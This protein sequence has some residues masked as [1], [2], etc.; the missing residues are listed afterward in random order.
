MGYANDALKIIF[1]YAAACEGGMLKGRS[2]D[3]RPESY[4]AQ[5]LKEMANPSAMPDISITLKYGMGMYDTLELR[6]NTSQLRDDQITKER[7][8][9]RLRESGYSN[10]VEKLDEQGSFEAQLHADFDLLRSLYGEPNRLYATWKIVRGGPSLRWAE[11][12]ELGYKPE[13]RKAPAVNPPNVAKLCDVADPELLVKQPAVDYYQLRGWGYS[14]IGTFITD[15]SATEAAYPGS[16]RLA[17]KAMRDTVDA[18]TLVSKDA[19]VDFDKE[20]VEHKW[21]REDFT[22][23]AET[24]GQTEAKFSISLA[25]ILE[26]N[27]KENYLLWEIGRMHHLRWY[28]PGSHNQVAMQNMS[29]LTEGA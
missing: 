21:A 9:Q 28:I 29:L 1:R 26:R 10:V 6:E 8:C 24:L 17:I 14:V 19:V 25:E 3:I 5:W 7:V 2:G 4:I 15:Y 16:Y 18:A 12:P 13:P 22:K 11:A 20:R 23:V 27:T